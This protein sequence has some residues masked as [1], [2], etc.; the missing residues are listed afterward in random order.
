MPEQLAHLVL[1][2]LRTVFQIA[3]VPLVD[4][5]TLVPFLLE[6]STLRACLLMSGSLSQRSKHMI[7]VILAVD[8]VRLALRV[9]YLAAVRL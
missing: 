1:S 9:A 5:L 4:G 3:L 2:L 8:R 6:G 7:L